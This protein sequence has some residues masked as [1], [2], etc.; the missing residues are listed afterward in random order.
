MSNK[1]MIVGTGNVGAS[2]GFCLASQRTAVNE[3]ILTDIDQADAEGETLDLR[4]TLAVSPTY[5]QINAGTYAD[6]K[7][8]DIIIITAGANQKEGETRLDLLQK[9]AEIM[10]GIV[11]PIMESGFNGIF[12]VVSNPMDVLT[13]MVWKFSGL[14]ENQVIGSGTVLDSARLCLRISEQ[15]NI[16]PKSVSAMQLGEHGDSEFTYW[17]GANIA[18]VPITNML[19]SAERESIE[20]F[21]RNEAYD[22]I[23]KKGATYY[24]IGACVTRIID[25]ILNDERRVMP[26]SSYDAYA[27]VYNGYPAILGRTGVISR[28]EINLSEQ[29]AISFQKS[30]NILREA[31]ESLEQ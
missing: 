13:Y 30:N 31:I 28:L 3:L 14:P 18:G 9:N 1:V 20:N 2:I 26:V 4:D 7:D 8:C 6:T 19:Q 29:E 15:L 22:I 23:N 17:S 16:H 11:S 27:N 25:C 5:L 12:L 10:E 21:A 24:G